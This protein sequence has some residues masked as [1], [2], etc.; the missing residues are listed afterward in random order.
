MAQKTNDHKKGQQVKL[1]VI[2]FVL[3]A[4]LLVISLF[5]FI[6]INLFLNPTFWMTGDTEPVPPTPLL[7]T[8]VNTALF[9]IGALGLVSLL[10]GIV[11]GVF[12]LRQAKRGQ[13]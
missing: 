11:A 3:P 1:A 9:C 6:V 12:L 7:I 4:V 5:L 10:P 8:I 2:A 13:R